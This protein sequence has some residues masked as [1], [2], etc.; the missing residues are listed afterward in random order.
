MQRL[1]DIAVVDEKPL[2]AL[3]DFTRKIAS[4]T[5]LL[6]KNKN[7]VLPLAHKK[8][9]VFGRIQSHYYK[10]GT[11]SG[12]LVNVDKVPSII[13][14]FKTHPLI[15]LDEFV[16]EHYQTWLK[17]H[18]YDAGNGQW[19]SE[20]WAQVEYDIPESIVEKSSKD[21][22]IAVVIFGRTAGEDKDAFYGK[23]SYLL[24]DLEDQLLKKVTKHFK[25]VVVRSE[26]HTSELQ[27]RPHLVCRLLLEKKKKKKK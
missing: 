8:V 9:A 13:E 1:N 5:V 20:P 15:Q 3:S 25:S 6:L 17:D 24:S 16:Y 10:S 27:S 14:S 21:N 11:G 26:E 12:G 22:D 18:P 2:K 23:G 7:N 4:E 19:A